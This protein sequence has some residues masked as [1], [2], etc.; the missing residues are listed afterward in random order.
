VRSTVSPG[1]T[2]VMV[3]ITG[4]G[5]GMKAIAAHFRY[6]SKNGRLDIED[7]RGE[8]MRGKD[9]LHDLADDWP[10]LPR[11]RLRVD[12]LDTL[13]RLSHLYFTGEQYG[14]CV[15]LCQ[16]LL[17]QDNC[18]EDAHCRLMRCY[19]RQD[20]HLLALRQYQTCAEALDH[21][22]G[23]APA[24]ATTQLYERIRRREAV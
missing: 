7:E 19:S 18:R 20:Q 23:V 17:A 14:R 12:Y 16:M 2:Q 6:I 22:L 5:R 4:G 21:E 9:T 24:A 8:T 13:D 3:K 15:T 1:A 10:V 11:E